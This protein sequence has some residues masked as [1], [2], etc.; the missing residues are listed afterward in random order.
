MPPT[1]QM[2]EAEDPVDLDDLLDEVTGEVSGR[3]GVLD[4]AEPADSRWTWHPAFSIA[5]LALIVIALAAIVRMDLVLTD[6]TPTGGDMGA[7][8]W[9]PAYLRDH[10][11]PHLRLTG[12]TPDWYT[13]F[14]AYTYYMVLPSLAIV[15]LDVGLVSVTSVTGLVIAGL[16]VVAAVAAAWWA[17]RLPNRL[18]KAGVWLACALGPLLLIDVPYNI[19]FKLIAVSGVL[20]LPIAVWYL[21]KGLGLMHPGPEL[22]A[23][24]T[25]MFL[26]DKTLFHIYG[27]NIAS[28]MA[29]EF[30]FSVSLSLS[31]FALGVVARGVRNGKGAVRA[32]VL[33]AA[34]ML[35]HPI[36]GL[37]FLGVAAVLVVAVEVLGRFIASLMA[38]FRHQAAYW[39][40]VLRPLAWAGIVAVPAGLLA[41][42]WYLPF[43][44]QSAFLNDMGWEKLG[45]DRCAEGLVFNWGQVWRNLLPFAPHEVTLCGNASPTTFSDPNMLHGRVIFVLAAIGVVLSLVMAVRSGIWLTLL[46]ATAG[47][48]FVVMPQHR[49]W[50]ARVLPFYYFGVFLLAAVGATLVLRL[51]VLVFSGRWRPMPMWVSASALTAVLVV[52]WVALGMTFRMMPGGTLVTNAQNQQVFHWGFFST[53]YQGVVADWAT[54][55]FE[56]LERKPGTTTQTKSDGTTRTF[57]DTTSSDEYFGMI[58][59]MDRIGAKRGC[60]RAYWEYDEALNRY[61]TPMAPM[62]LPYY[63]DG[64][65]GSMEGL[66]F[67]ASSTTPFHFLVQSELSQKPSRPQRFDE[68]L[69]FDTSPYQ[70]FNIEAGVTHLQM[71][72]VRYFMALTD[73]TKAA[74]KTE[75]RLTHVATSGPWEIYEVADISLVSP[76][77]HLPEVWTD[78]TDNI[79]DWAS[80]A[81]KWFNDPKAWDV[82]GATSGPKS[83]PRG[84]STKRAIERDAPAPDVK[85]SDVRTTRSSIS[86]RV[87]EVGSPV[88]IRTSF[89][90]NWDAEGAEGPYRVTPN[91][92]V[93]VPTSKRVELTYG[94]SGL[95]VIGGLASLLGFIAVLL[96]IWRP[97]PRDR[98]PAVV[99]FGDRTGGGDASAWEPGTDVLAGV[100]D[101][102]GVD[103]L[104]DVDDPADVDPLADV[105]DPA[106]ADAPADVDAVPPIDA[107]GR[108]GGGA[109]WIP[110]APPPLPAPPAPDPTMSDGPDRPPIEP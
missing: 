57:I 52:V 56:G 8:V 98:R 41:L 61:G 108:P 25:V 86:F 97:L 29:G 72:G 5:T 31:V 2:D 105:D 88:L 9:G 94:R 80:P 77:S 43:Y 73:A 21:F 90:P 27:G 55:N 96:L 3:V 7:H 48:A 93:V 53:T 103:A 23:V 45:P 74:A 34:A 1:L 26:A 69:G 16:L 11:L 64:C 38:T 78:V 109:L 104:A 35:C 39:G 60:G 17:R 79:H 106:G 71:L 19:A 75:S 4:G 18:A 63:T 30:A 49:F 6:T 107:T 66:Y 101:P 12:W 32:I 99:F 102:A 42:W 95:E 70:N 65:I 20:T 85:V 76:L 68:N 51:L 28:T 87:D 13:G 67:E 40:S 15:A 50:N 91:F 37:F 58:R 82:L 110:P 22:G 33:L 83:W 54:W 47:I 46:T 89:F 44:G 36:P 100:D 84:T 24:A 14:P 10:L 59:E 81:V 62:L 92:M